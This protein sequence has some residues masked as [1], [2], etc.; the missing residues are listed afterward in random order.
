MHPPFSFR[1]FP[2]RKRAVHGPKEKGARRAPVQWPSARDGGRRIGACSDFA[3]PSGTLWSSA[4]L[5]LP[6][7]DGWCGGRRGAGTHL[8]SSSFRAF[9]FATRSPG[10]RG[11]LYQRADEGVRP[12]NGAMA[13]GIP[14]GAD[15]LI[16]PLQKPHQPPGQ[17]Q[18]KAAQD[19]S[20]TSPGWR[21]P[22]GQRVSV[23]DCRKGL[24][25]IP[26]RRQEVCAGAQ[27]RNGG[28]ICPAI[29][30]AVIPRP[31]GRTPPSAGKIFSNPCNESPANRT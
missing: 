19:V 9:R 29:S 22:Q 13:F 5:M 16:G 10:G 27:K 4:R 25:T 23:P 11:G 26:R 15:S 28:C 31:M 6:S 18:R 1:S 17:R 21:F 12:Y 14:V 7:R 30:M 24:P 8:T 20:Q 3:W 2:K